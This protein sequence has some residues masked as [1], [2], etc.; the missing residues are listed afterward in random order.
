MSKAEIEV[1]LQPTLRKSARG[2][3][4]LV[5]IYLAFIA[6]TLVCEG[7][8]MYAYRSE[9]VMLA[10]LATM[11]VLT[12]GFLAYGI[13]IASELTAIDRSDSSL[14]DAL[15]QR[16]RFYHTR[17]EL[18]LWMLTATIPF[19][20]FAVSALADADQGPYRINKPWLFTAFTAIQVTCMYIILKVGH[21]PLIREQ[22]AILA[23]MESQAT[24]ETDRVRTL[25]RTWRLWGAL[26]V[27]V[28]VVLLIL[29]ILRATS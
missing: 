25:K 16:L 8:S 29:G 22:K 12:A 6:V 27:L 20:S 18:W 23:D 15:R 7:M 5:W 28:G 19:L 21:Y 1:M 4:V 2:W 24:T 26:A 14:V 11:T 3:S 13:H 10:V 9:P 17:Y